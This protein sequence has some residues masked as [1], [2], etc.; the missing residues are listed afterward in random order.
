MN[1]ETIQLN[2]NLADDSYVN[3]KKDEDPNRLK[4]PIN[5]DGHQYYVLKTY[6]NSTTGFYGAVYQDK[7]TN[8]ITVA[9]RGTEP[10]AN[11]AADIWTDT[12]IVH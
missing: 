9:Y 4:P 1:R 7:A 2:A 12:K 11:K 10:L 5:I 3:R 6:Q 8:E